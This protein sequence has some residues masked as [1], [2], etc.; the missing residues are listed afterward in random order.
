MRNA[1]H[2]GSIHDEGKWEGGMGA[3]NQDFFGSWLAGS[4]FSSQPGGPPCWDNPLAFGLIGWLLLTNLLGLENGN[5]LDDLCVSRKVLC[6]PG[7]RV[8]HS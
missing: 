6:E 3:G 4:L 5:V 2:A 7:G 1:F 8:R